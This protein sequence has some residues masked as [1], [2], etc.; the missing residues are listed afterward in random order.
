MPTYKLNEEKKGIEIYFDE[1]PT[2]TI[3]EQ[4]KT[5]SFR[6]SGRSKC[7]YAKQNENTLNL[8]KLITGADTPEENEY[9]SSDITDE[10]LSYPY[11]DIDDNY[12]Y[13]VDQ[14]L[15]DREH[16]GNWIM[17]SSK[18]DRTKEIQ[19]Y[20]TQL[21]CEVKEIIS[22][23]S[24]EYIIYQLKKTLQYYK[25][26]YFNN[27]VARL[28]NRA[29][30]PSWLVTGR[31]GRNSTRDQKMN[32]RYDK[33]MQEYIELDN[34]YKRRISALTSK[35]RKEKEQAIR[36]QIEQTEVNITFKTE[37]KEFTYMNMKEKKRVYVHEE[38]WICKLWACFRV[39]KNGKEVHSM[40][41]ADKL[42]DAKKYVTMLVIQERQAS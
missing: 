29:D 40:K 37:T 6:W 16:D 32:N 14:Q 39:F 22:T 26:H 27:Y 38:Y 13:V 33:L 9:N 25:K 24:N 35:I 36:Q 17:R 11:I 10:A 34:D 2:E 7:W 18:P 21:T 20:F 8:A 1:K 31:G 3:R 28:K 19:E 30:S 42:E 5:C 15:Q 12:T 23:I 4:L 41:T